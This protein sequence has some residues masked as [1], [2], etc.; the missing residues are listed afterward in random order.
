M[1]LCKDYLEQIILANLHPRF[2]CATK[3]IFAVTKS[4]HF[5]SEFKCCIIGMIN[6]QS[7]HAA[8]GDTKFGMYTI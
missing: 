1:V 2:L 6:R 8:K 7:P 4:T 5:K 3:L